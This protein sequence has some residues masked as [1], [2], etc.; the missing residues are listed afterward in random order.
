MAEV[1]SESL[2]YPDVKKRAVASRS[3]R[4]KIPSSNATSFTPTQ[5]IN[6]DLPGNLSGQ[7]YNFNQMYLKFKCVVSADSTTK[8]LKWD[9]GGAV[10]AIKRVQISTAGSSICDLNNYNVLYTAL[11]DTDASV[12]WKASSGNILTGTTSGLVGE[13]IP[14]ATP[15]NGGVSRTYCVPIVLNPL[16]NTTPHRLIPAFSM[17]ALQFKITLDSLAQMG[18]STGGASPTSIQFEEVEMVC[19]MTELS[20][21]AQSQV[22][23]MTGGVYN[24]LA[25][26]YMNSGATMNAGVSSVTANLGFSVSSLER[27][28]L[29]QRPFNNVQT[30]Y[31]IGNRSANHLKEYQY[32][33]NSENYPQ[34]PIVVSDMNA[35]V[36]SELLLADHSL[37][38][39][40]KG[41]S[42]QAGA[43]Q[44]LDTSS[45]QTSLNQDNSKLDYKT[46]PTPFD[47][48]EPVGNS[49][50]TTVALN[51]G[52][53]QPSVAS[54]IGTFLAGCEFETGLSDGKSQN[55]YSGIST[56]ASTVQFKGIYN[57]GTP[58][59][60]VSAN[61][62][63]DFFAQ[64][65]VMLSLDM[66]GSG[67]WNVSV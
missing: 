57:G 37:T 20:P 48:Q 30:K 64:Y 8:G 7:Y 10:S 24:I 32:L 6:I 18:I 46:R 44:S 41:N 11:L 5:T 28:L 26:S 15:A 25:N 47:L 2:N 4:V 40:R 53:P 52:V 50:G 65:S 54:N 38:D 1:F 62:S 39:F 56:I 58:G 12:E 66:R 63:L 35:E 67:V 55:I 23:R 27:I 13:E 49:G 3:F 45:L 17:S 61:C 33:I 51:G 43:V 16:A 36:C 59:A 22:D 14:S 29:V 60:G 34:R 9:R 21:S 19:Q 42:L 31:T